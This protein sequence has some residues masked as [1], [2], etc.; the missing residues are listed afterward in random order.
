MGYHSRVQVIRRGQ[1]NRQYYLICPSALAQ[2]LELEKGEMIEWVV[3][4]KQTL[5]IRRVIREGNGGLDEG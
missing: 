5:T 1:K 2:A 3:E 4:D